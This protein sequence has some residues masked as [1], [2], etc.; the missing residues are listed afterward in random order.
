MG[1]QFQVTTTCTDCRQVQR[2]SETSGSSPS[3]PPSP[4]ELST[5]HSS[6]ERGESPAY[7]VW[8]FLVSSDSFFL[9][10]STGSV[11]IIGRRLSLCTLLCVCVFTFLF[12]WTL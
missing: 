2:K 4:R 9:S 5:M 7:R 3:V 10:F 1:N 8:T 12:V 6:R 11:V